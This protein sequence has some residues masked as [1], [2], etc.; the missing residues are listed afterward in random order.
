MVM[1]SIIRRRSGQMASGLMEGSVEGEANLT[2]FDGA[3]RRPLQHGRT[4]A[5]STA[6]ALQSFDAGLWAG[7]GEQGSSTP[8]PGC[9]AEQCTKRSCHL[10]TGSS[11]P[12]S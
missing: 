3:S 9:A 5:A 7:W 8:P 10:A 12:D 1:S 4:L 2:I 6:R 11:N